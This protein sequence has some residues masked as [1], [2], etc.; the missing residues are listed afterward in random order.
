MKQQTLRI[1]VRLLLI[2]VAAAFLLTAVHLI[3][4]PYI[5]AQRIAKIESSV[6]SLFAQ[7]T[8]VIELDASQT[9]ADAVYEVKGE[10]G[11]LGYAVLACGNGYGGELQLMVGYTESG[12]ICGVRVISDGETQ[13]IGSRALADSYLAQYDGK[14][15]SLSLSDVDGISGATRSVKGILQAVNRANAAMEVVLA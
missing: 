9:E 1:G 13:G 12:T 4:A 5:E 10:A 8:E 3:T 7:A 14:H 11:R 6:Q 15:G 2:C